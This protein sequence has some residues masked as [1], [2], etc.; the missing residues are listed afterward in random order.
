MQIVSSLA[1][2]AICQIYIANGAIWL[3]RAFPLASDPALSPIGEI[4]KSLRFSECQF[5][6]A[7]SRQI[8]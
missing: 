3:P 2:S 4:A 1:F 7:D 8:S 5:I 6:R